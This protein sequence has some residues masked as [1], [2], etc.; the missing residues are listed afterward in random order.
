MHDPLVSFTNNLG[1][2]DL[3]ML[4]A[5]IGLD[6]SYLFIQGP[7]GAGKTYISAHVIIELMKLGKKAGIASN[8]HKAVHNLL[9]KIESVAGEKNFSFHGFKK[10]SGK[11]NE[12][13]FQ[14]RFIQ[15]KTKVNEMNLDANLFAGTA[16]TFTDGHFHN[17]LDY[18]FI[19]EAGQV[20]TANV[21]AMAVATENIILVE[22]QMQLGQPIQGTHPGEARLSIL[23]FLQ[24]DD[25][26]ISDD[27]GVFLGQTWR[28]SPSI[29][30]FIS[31]AFY[32]GRLTAHE[33]ARER[34][35]DL[36][37]TGDFPM[38]GS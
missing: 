24:G 5:I 20:S 25:S 10:S 18:L 22:D 37:D 15:N 9:E 8:S 16:W 12:T 6:H 34:S 28:L 27:R 19:D 2:R 3:R 23:E 14:G 35:L 17:Q 4:K 33:S 38:K 32:D 30:K 11:D 13:C 1:E 7:P 31:D 29:C 26:T 36:K 21:V